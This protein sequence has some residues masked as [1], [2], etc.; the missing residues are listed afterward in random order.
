MLEYT[1]NSLVIP[2]VKNF[3]M[4]IETENRKLLYIQLIYFI[5]IYIYFFFYI[6]EQETVMEFGRVDKDTFVCNYRNPLSAIQAFG[7]AL[8][9]FDSGLTRE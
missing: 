3:Q 4:V 8:S 7:I 1:G 6:D 2:S 5:Y 9:S